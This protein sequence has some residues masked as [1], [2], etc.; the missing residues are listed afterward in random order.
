MIKHEIW[1]LPMFKQTHM[2]A[3]HASSLA[4]NQFTYLLQRP[5][6]STKLW[7]KIQR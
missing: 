2:P 7:E 5:F 6:L 4:M 1:G 3:I